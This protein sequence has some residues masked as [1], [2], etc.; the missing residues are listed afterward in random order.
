[1]S[2]DYLS[3]PYAVPSH[4]L[5]RMARLGGLTG[6]LLGRAALAGA[7]DLARG[8]RPALGSAFLTP[9][10]AAHLASELARMRGAAMKLGQL[11]SMEAGEYLSPDLADILSRLRSEAHAMPGSQLKR[12]LSDNWGTDFLTRFRS[13]DVRPVA[14][15]SIGQ[16]HRA[17]TKDG[18]ALA[19]KVQYPGVRDSIDSDIRN[20]G[21]LMRWSG[22]APRGMDLSALLEDARAQLHDEADYGAEA[23]M[24]DRFGALLAD[25]PRFAVPEGVPEFSTRDILAMTWMDGVPIETL[26]AA[27]QELRDEVAARLITLTLRELFAFRLVQTDPNFAN[28]RWNAEAGRTVL[29]DFGAARDYPEPL[30]A[31]FRALLR[32]GLAGDRD[33]MG[34]AATRIGYLSDELSPARLSALLD[35]M[36]MCFEPLRDDRPFDFARSDLP[37]RLTAAAMAF[38]RDRDIAPVPPADALFLQRKVAG[39]YLLAARLGA[40]VALRPLL[41][42]YA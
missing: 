7:R 18:R 39:L 29:L 38:G 17:E 11:L 27:D 9:A 28:F 13:F 6:G 26:A 23:R 22:L 37:Q 25:D 31:E 2:D 33:D 16:V 8:R 15:A 21:A 30:V 12:V 24:L 20:L 19:V 5:G 42:P 32:A 10:N 3:R 4:R 1:M 14:A 34:A 40:R 36:E 41:A 35:M